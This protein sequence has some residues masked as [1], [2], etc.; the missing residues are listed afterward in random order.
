MAHHPEDAPYVERLQAMVD[1]GQLTGRPAEAFPDI[2]QKA[3][4]YRLT[5]GQKNYIDSVARRLMGDEPLGNSTGYEIPDLRYCTAE[6]DVSGWVVHIKLQNGTKFPVGKALTRREVISI[7]HWL[8]DA[9]PQMIDGSPGEMSP[10]T[11]SPR[12][13]EPDVMGEFT[14]EDEDPLPF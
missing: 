5:A 4:R 3:N 1:S 10:T 2:L 14:E 7:I 11:E 6:K 13:A 8:D 9:L 12:P